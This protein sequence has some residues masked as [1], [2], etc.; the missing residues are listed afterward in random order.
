MASIGGVN[1]L[2]DY[3]LLP[4]IL[5]ASILPDI[6][7]TKSIIGKIFFPIAQVIN[8]KYGH[9]TITHS[10]FAVGWNKNVPINAL[11]VSSFSKI[12]FLINLYWYNYDSISIFNRLI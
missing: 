12:L 2:Q 6:D 9:R 5:I 3:R 4:I 1:I 7:H 10:V 8:R 11:S